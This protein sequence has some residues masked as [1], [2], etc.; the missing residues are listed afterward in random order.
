MLSG[1][2]RGFE[3]IDSVFLSLNFRESFDRVAWVWVGT[4]VSIV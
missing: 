1:K 4:D 2:I 3:L